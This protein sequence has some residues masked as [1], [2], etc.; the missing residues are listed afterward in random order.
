MARQ[1]EFL[2]TLNTIRSWFQNLNTGARTYTFPDRNMTIAG[3]DD[4]TTIADVSVTGTVS[5]TTSAFG[6][7]HLCSGTSADYTI[8]LPTA[9]GF[10][11][12]SIAFFGTYS[13]TKKVTIDGNGSQTINGQLTH[14]FGSGKI[15]IVTSDGTNWNIT[16]RTGRREVYFSDNVTTALHTGDTAEFLVH[17]IFI[18]ANYIKPNDKLVIRAEWVKTG[19]AGAWNLKHRFHT[20][21]AV[22]GSSIM[23]PNP[24]STIISPSTERTV[25]CKNS[26]TSQEVLTNTA[27]VLVD[28]G[29][30]QNT[31][32]TALSIDFTVDQFLNSTIQNLNAADSGGLASIIFEIVRE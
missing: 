2:N 27:N 18:P 13:L 16:N 4:V 32:R 17:S 10:E 22:G 26:Q 5:L 9:A 8:D 25:V 21:A 23:A 28:L 29:T 3:L 31:A 11:G 1:I 20:S 14:R 15:V 7:M 19:T 30:A 24:A 12:Q 6:K